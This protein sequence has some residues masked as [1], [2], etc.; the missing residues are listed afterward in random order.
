MS[1]LTDE[2]SLPV[3]VIEIGTK[4]VLYCNPAMEKLKEDKIFN[5]YGKDI[6]IISNV[7]KDSEKREENNQFISRSGWINYVYQLPVFN[8]PPVNVA[9]K[10]IKYRG[11][12]AILF[13]VNCDSAPV[14]VSSKMVGETSKIFK[15]INSFSTKPEDSIEDLLKMFGELFD[16]DCVI[17]FMNDK[18]FKKYF[19]CVNK[20]DDRIKSLSEAIESNME[21]LIEIYKNY[22]PHKIYEVTAENT[23]NLFVEFQKENPDICDPK[24]SKYLVPIKFPSSVRNDGLILVV[25]ARRVFNENKYA[26]S[27]SNMLSFFYYVLTSQNQI[28]ELS[29]YDNLTG[30]Y[31]RNS[32]IK[33]KQ[34]LIS[35]PPESIGVVFLDINGLKI[36]N[37]TYGHN[38]GDTVIIST[39]D[40]IKSIF[41]RTSVYRIG[42]DEFVIILTNTSRNEFEQK[43]RRLKQIL[44]EER[45][46]SVSIGT[47]YEEGDQ[48]NLEQMLENADKKMYVQK[49]TYYKLQR[50]QKGIGKMH[51]CHI[52]HQIEEGISK[53][54]FSIFLRPRFDLKSNF[55][56]GADS[57]L[58]INRPIFNI[59]NS[60]QLVNLLEN[61]D[62]M[63]PIDCHMIELN[64]QFHKKMIDKY[65]KSVTVSI[66]FSNKTFQ[67]KDFKN[68][69]LETVDKYKIPY[70]YIN[71]QI[72]YLEK[73]ISP[74]LI[75]TV[76]E[77]NKKGFHTS[78]NHFGVGEAVFKPLQKLLLNSVKLDNS[79]TPALNNKKGVITLKSIIKMTNDLNIDA[80]VDS[81][82]NEKQI[83][84]AIEI[85]FK[86]GRGDYYSKSVNT[87]KFE[88]QFIVPFLDK[89]K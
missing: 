17:S 40:A 89:L 73:Q 35:T 61:A 60:F 46:S 26:S 79:L 9:K 24:L 52:R 64:C 48:L 87:G 88:K 11:K 84:K 82:K 45:C 10:K 27:L 33:N 37:D 38:F 63:Y 7:V 66:N 15:A 80:C 77:L 21:E 22:E 29:F 19:S 6:D 76:N 1:E 13:V 65:G 16:A 55:V 25:N 20:S 41:T 50:Q 81:I 44:M 3:F 28:E 54:Q 53:G 78:I 4:K 18:T 31:N 56:T 23:N 68:Y 49:Q 85:G 12:D 86:N 71:L 14:A 59:S 83:E 58:H 32:Y 36:T 72:I 42:G 30:F 69:L 8:I 34:N 43:V 5:L 51:L 62:L 57:L 74:A 2:F 67:H 75:A 70:R 39:S 47:T